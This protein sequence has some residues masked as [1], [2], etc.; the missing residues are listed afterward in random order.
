MQSVAVVA[1]AILAFGV[2]SNRA[3]AAAVTPPMAFVALGLALGPWGLGYVTIAVETDFVH[4]LAEATLVVILFTDASRIDLALLRRDHGVPV[5]LLVI[6]LPLTIVAG[7]LAAVA[8]LDVPSLW[9]AAVVAAVLAPTDAALGQAVVS[10]TSVPVRIRQALNVESGLN[11]GIAL[12]AVLI[13]VSVAEATHGG[14]GAAYWLQFAAL[15]VVLGPI[16]GIAVGYAGGKALERGWQA[17]WT[18]PTF[19]KLSGLGLAFLAFA[20]A[21]LVGGNGFIAAFAAGL[22]MGNSA[23][24]ICPSL[25]AFGEAEG[26]LMALMTFLIFGAVMVPDAIPHMSWNV[27]LYGALSLTAV[28][29]VPVAVSLIGLPLRADTQLFL[30]W[31]GPRGIASILFVLVV[32]DE[33][34]MTRAADVAVVVTAVL[35]SVFAQ[36]VTARP[37]A[38]L[39]GARLARAA[40]ARPMIETEAVGE[41]PLRLRG[42]G[43]AGQG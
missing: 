41:M 27:I 6:G 30:G 19:L 22:T 9:V 33:A 42:R 5:R 38:A 39:Y 34:P 13:L 18:D 32:L 23:R 24:S 21:D 10:S 40:P 43:A 2:I 28:R 31:F 12:P 25:Y 1:L 8:I 3:A 29:M 11:D 4:L 15:Q 36:G 20:A 17:G 26:Q 37:A 7:T 14:A 35:M 16:V